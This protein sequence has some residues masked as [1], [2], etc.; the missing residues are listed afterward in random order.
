MIAAARVP[1]KTAEVEDAY[2]AKSGGEL[3]PPMW[4]ID[5]WRYRG[6]W[7]LPEGERIV[8]PVAPGGERVTI[9]LEARYLR[10]RHPPLTL[11]V[12][13]GDREIGSRDF[14]EE[15]DWATVELGPFDWPDGGALTLEAT[16]P[17]PPLDDLQKNRL[18]I[19]RLRFRWQ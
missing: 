1:T 6:A 18:I 5:R 14:V 19:D 13:A 2:V 7:L 11:R 9:E 16:G 8:V 4:T 10:R 17:E 3:N 12:A 15:S